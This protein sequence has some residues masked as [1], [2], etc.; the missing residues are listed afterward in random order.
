[1]PLQGFR[2]VVKIIITTSTNFSKI[3][4]QAIE[5]NSYITLRKIV[6]IPLFMGIK[7]INFAATFINYTF[8]I[9]D[10]IKDQLLDFMIQNL[11]NSLLVKYILELQTIIKKVVNFMFK[12]QVI[13]IKVITVTDTINFLK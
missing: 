7:F 11:N 12:D 8:I 2:K 6:I 3:I 13:N 9:K 4:N 10:I 1:M 5:I